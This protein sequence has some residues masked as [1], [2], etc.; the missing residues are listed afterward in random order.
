MQSTPRG[1]APGPYTQLIAVAHSIG[2]T[3]ARPNGRFLQIRWS[4]RGWDLART[5]CEL[6]ASS[7]MAGLNPLAARLD[8][9]V[10][11]V[12][13]SVGMSIKATVMRCDHN[14]TSLFG[15]TPHCSGNDGRVRKALMRG[16]LICQ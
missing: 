16:R 15:E 3:V 7:E 1:R 4:G 14:G 8:Q 11:D 10:L 2:Y 9:P 5:K 6:A 12:D 13:H